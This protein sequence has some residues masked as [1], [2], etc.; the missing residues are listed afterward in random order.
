MRGYSLRIAEAIKKADGSL[1]GVK[2][3]RLCLARDIPV[4]VVA[5]KLGVT[6]Q[7]VY[8]WF[9]GESDPRGPMCDAIEAYIKSLR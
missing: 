4:S 3:G 6:R 2:L 8:A 1:L 9:T 7:A 5:D